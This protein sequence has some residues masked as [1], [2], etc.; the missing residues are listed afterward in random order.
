M[1]IDQFIEELEKVKSAVGGNT[2][3]G[4][5]KQLG[6]RKGKFDPFWIR[7]VEPKVT[8]ESGRVFIEP[9]E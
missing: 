3:L 5:P 8:V 6:D 4:I 2:P 7:L 1:T 9:A